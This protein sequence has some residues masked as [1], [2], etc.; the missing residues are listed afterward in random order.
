ME[1]YRC[2][3]E[4]PETLGRTVATIGNFDG[5][6]LGHREIFRRVRRRAEQERAASVVVTFVPHPLKV[7][8]DRNRQIQLIN[9]Y[10]EKET[11]IEASGMDCMLAIPFTTDFASISP[12]EFVADVLVKRLSVTHLII[13]YDYSFGRNRQGD[14]TTLRELGREFGFTVEVLEPIGHHGMVYSSSNVRS[15]ITQGDVAGVV[16]LLGR[17][18]SLG[19]IVVKGHGRGVDLGFPTAN[20]QS[21][22]DLVPSC[23]VYAVKVKLDETLHDGACNIGNNPTFGN[24]HVSI[25]VYLFDFNEELYGKELRIYFVARIREERTFPGINELTLAIAADVAHCRDILDTTPLIEYR[26]YL[27]AV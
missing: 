5:V 11:L 1:I 25:E 21:D 18:F 26:E 8:P 3:E 7:I 16:P 10:A 12:R 27:E 9:T 24:D 22:K 23:G 19:G 6:H 15:L 13:G 17:H 20:I 4:I 2:I 14:V